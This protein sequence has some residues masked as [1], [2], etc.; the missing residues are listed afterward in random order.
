MGL[1]L[2]YNP[3]NIESTKRL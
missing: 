1:C 2:I 3:R